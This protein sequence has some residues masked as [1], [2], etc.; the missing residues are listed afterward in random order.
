MEGDAEVYW[1]SGMMGRVFEG[2]L[3]DVMGDRADDVI[4]LD[5]EGSLHA[6]PAANEHA[7]DESSSAADSHAQPSGNTDVE[8]ARTVELREITCDSAEE[9][10]ACLV[11]FSS[12]AEAGQELRQ[13]LESEKTAMSQLAAGTVLQLE[14]GAQY[15]LVPR[16]WLQQWRAFLGTAGKRATPLSPGS[17]AE[18]PAPGPLMQAIANSCCQCHHS[19]EQPRLNHR[20]PAVT[21]RRG[22]WILADPGQETFEAI[23]SADWLKLL[24]FHAAD[25]PEGSSHPCREIKAVLQVCSAPTLPAPK[26]YDLAAG[27]LPDENVIGDDLQAVQKAAGGRASIAD[28]AELLTDPLVCL[29]AVREREEHVK[30]CKLAYVDEEVLV[31]LVNESQLGDALTGERKSKRARKGR[32]PVTVSGSSTIS[33]LKMHILEAL[34]VHPRNARIFKPIRHPS[35]PL[36][37]FPLDQDDRTLAEYEVYAGEELK[38]VDTEQFD[39]DDLGSLFGSP[40]SSSRHETGFMGTALMGIQPEIAL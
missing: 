4:M 8:H 3:G 39:A 35:K 25:L 28:S 10:A 26:M 22:R 23:S 37:W 16:T 30:K 11:E 12:H 20:P 34:S 1:G 33:D 38:V 29:E 9:C 2:L 31:E 32:T 19:C 13:H 7:T 21:K 40:G 15:N 17:A 14:P 6:T 5:H 24:H 18:A 27:T 36:D